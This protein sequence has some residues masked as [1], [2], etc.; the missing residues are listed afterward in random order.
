MLCRIVRKGRS[1]LLT[2][3]ITARSNERIKA[4]RAL[5]QAKERRLRGLHLVESDKLVLEALYSG[6]NIK[7]VFIENTFVD[8]LLSTAAFP[9]ETKITPVSRA[10]M[11]ALSESKTPQHSCAIVETPN[12]VPPAVYPE[13]L[14]VILDCVQDPGNVGTILRTADALGASALFVGSGTADP[15]SGKTL[16]AAMGSTYHLPIYT[17]DAVEA[18]QALRKQGFTCICGHLK[19]EST[20]PRLSSKT[21]LVIGNEGNGVSDTV[22]EACTLYKLPMRGRAESLNAAIAAALLIY[23]L[24]NRM[25]T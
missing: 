2:S 10:V 22:A 25:E 5:T 1:H 23:E 3:P 8:T 24:S 13:G 16:R 17:G 21:A 6:C 15:F 18:V 7:E 12:L 11:E 19:G 20:L 14:V 9:G 4:A